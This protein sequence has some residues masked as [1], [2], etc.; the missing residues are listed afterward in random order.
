MHIRAA[1][2]P[3]SLAKGAEMQLGKSIHLGEKDFSSPASSTCR[4]ADKLA[5]VLQRA[6]KAQNPLEMPILS[7]AIPGPPGFFVSH[8]SYE[9][10]QTYP[11]PVSLRTG[12]AL[13]LL[14]FTVHLSPQHNFKA[15]EHQAQSEKKGQ[16]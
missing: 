7:P 12:P 15:Q 3:D 11:P 8:R 5:D 2:L 4:A 6:L 10:A 9:T 1:L 16:I 13:V 14:D